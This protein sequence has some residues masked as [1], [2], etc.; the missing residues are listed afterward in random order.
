MDDDVGEFSPVVLHLTSDES[1]D[2]S[3]TGSDGER[4]GS[5]AGSDGEKDGLSEKEEGEDSSSPIQEGAISNNH[6]S[7]ELRVV[8]TIVHQVIFYFLHLTMYT[9]P[10]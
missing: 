7:S 9:Y 5:S 2:E 3:S 8:G 6:S 10:T 1:G 4:D